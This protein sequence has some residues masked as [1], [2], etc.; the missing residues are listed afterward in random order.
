MKGGACT[1][2]R[3]L[4][5]DART[6]CLLW[7]FCNNPSGREGD[8]KRMGCLKLRRKGREERKQ[9]LKRS[10]IWL[11][12][13]HRGNQTGTP[14][15]L[16]VLLLLRKLLFCSA[17]SCCSP[18]GEGAVDGRVD[19]QEPGQ[20]ACELNADQQ[21]GGRLPAAPPSSP[22]SPIAPLSPLENYCHITRLEADG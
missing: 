4:T 13:T 3:N 14:F 21:Q 20:T 12:L 5:E 8:L 15:F 7:S 2:L 1:P 6:A 9:S 17:T 19:G 10:Y 22:P 11:K 18:K 16:T